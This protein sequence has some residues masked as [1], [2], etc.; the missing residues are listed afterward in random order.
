MLLHHDRIDDL[1]VLECQEAEPA[2]AAGG[3]ISHHRTF[4]DFAEL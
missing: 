2:G 4:D 3:A 1:R